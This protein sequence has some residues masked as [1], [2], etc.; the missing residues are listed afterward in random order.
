MIDIGLA[1]LGLI[2]GFLV[3]LTSA[4][5]GSLGT[6]LLVV[7]YGDPASP[8]YIPGPVLVGSST[9]QG[10]AMKGVGTLRNWLDKS[11]E[12]HYALWIIA[13]ALPF[14]AVGAFTT[15]AVFRLGLFEVVL[16]VVLLVAA[17]FIVFEAA[18]MERARATSMPPLTGRFKAASAALGAAV[19]F[20]AGLTSVGTGTI[21]ISSLILLLRV[22]PRQAT[23][24]AILVG[25]VVL[26][27]ASVSH[28]AQGNID[29]EVVALLLAGSIPGVLVGSRLRG[30]LDPEPLRLAIAV[31]IAIASA[32][33]LIK[34][35]TGSNFFGL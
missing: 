28:L 14:T 32:R 19:G 33:L 5:T 3:G 26:L 23:P 11:L 12:T 25:A 17:F 22:P 2:V 18:V 27:G 34:A 8:P 13:G 10:T 15:G 7:F 35:I 1:L 21:V 6:T 29:L 16:A 30:R 9:L 4:G 31:V 24:I 20:L